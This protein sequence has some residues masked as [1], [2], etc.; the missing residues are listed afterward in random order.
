MCV[1]WDSNPGPVIS[2]SHESGAHTLS[3]PYSADIRWRESSHPQY[4]QAMFV[5]ILTEELSL[6]SICS[7]EEWCADTHMD[8]ADL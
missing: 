3:Y 8:G 2:F 5:L 7:T 4:E 6:F 1:C